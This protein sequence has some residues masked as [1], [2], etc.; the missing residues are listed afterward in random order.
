[1]VNGTPMVIKVAPIGPQ[2][3]YE[4]V[5][6]FNSDLFSTAVEDDI[7][8]GGGGSDSVAIGHRIEIHKRDLDASHDL[9]L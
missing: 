4:V 1:V 3:S 7:G 9:S 6:G 2:N 8:E 5:R